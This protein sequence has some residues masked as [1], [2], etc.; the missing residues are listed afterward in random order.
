M[1]PHD[2]SGGRRL[3]KCACRGRD[4]YPPRLESAA[5]KDPRALSLAIT[6]MEASLGAFQQVD[7]TFAPARVSRRRAA[8]P[9]KHGRDQSVTFVRRRKGDT[10]RVQT[11]MRILTT[12][13]ISLVR[14]SRGSRGS[15]L[16]RSGGNVPCHHGDAF[17][18]Y[19]SHLRGGSRALR[20]SSRNELEHGTDPGDRSSAARSRSVE[21]R[22]LSQLIGTLS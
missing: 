11:A 9:G 6:A 8:R 5:A 16:R 12:G 18:N 14:W 3:P 4:G 20:A 2:G 21:E 19:N 10:L 13:Q 17:C 22:R 15:P 7:D 1:S